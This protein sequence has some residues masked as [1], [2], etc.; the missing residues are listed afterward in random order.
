MKRTFNSLCER[1]AKSSPHVVLLGRT[2]QLEIVDLNDKGRE[3]MDKHELPKGEQEREDDSLLEEDT[4]QD[5]A[6]TDDVIVE[7]L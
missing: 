4:M 7:L 6:E 1:L 3:M 2:S 5:L